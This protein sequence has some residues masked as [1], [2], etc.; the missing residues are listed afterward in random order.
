[1][2]TATKTTWINRIGSNSAHNAATCRH[3]R[4]WAIARMGEKDGKCYFELLVD[5]FRTRGEAE[6]AL[7][8]WAVEIRSGGFHRPRA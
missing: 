4:T 8:A 7:E 1:M 5:G 6:G 2:T 3:G